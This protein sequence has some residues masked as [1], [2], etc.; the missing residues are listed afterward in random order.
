MKLNRDSQILLVRV[1][2]EVLLVA[3]AMLVFNT[4][5]SYVQNQRLE[6]YKDGARACQ[7]IYGDK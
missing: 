7:K 3:F 5:Q 6:A 4:V 2:M 1:A